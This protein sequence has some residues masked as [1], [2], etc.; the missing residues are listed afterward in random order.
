MPRGVRGGLCLGSVLGVCLLTPPRAATAR[1]LWSSYDGERT[2]SLETALKGSFLL[3]HAPEDPILFPERDSAAALWRLRLGLK[4]D[5]SSWASMSLD[6]E[7]RARSLSEGAGMG[8]AFVGLPSDAPYRVCQLDQPLVEIGDTFSYRHELD[9]AFVSF[10]SPRA[11]ITVGRQAIGWGRG[12]FFGAVD[13]FS[14]FTPLEVDR[15]WRRGIDALRADLRLSDRFSLDLVAAFGKTRED[16]ALLGRFR[17]YAGNADWELILG[18]RAQ[19]AMYAGTVSAAI[20][21]AE[22]HCEL[23]VF[24]VPTGTADGG[25]FGR[26]DLVGVGVLGCS[27]SFNVGN[28]LSL[29]A[30]YHYS[31]FGL[32]DISEAM[33]RLLNDEDFQ[34]RLARGDMRILGRNAVAVQLSYPLSE[35]WTMG[36]MWLL[37]SSDGSGVV[38]PTFTWNFADNVTLVFNASLPHGAPPEGGELRSEYGATPRSAFLQVRIYD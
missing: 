24:K 9:R 21:D 11:E 16:S 36:F 17:G 27:Y 23:A 4:G 2:L 30:E 26:D 6:Y 19:D 3:S 31:G 10:H 1:D 37:S 8:G 20:G 12:V 28:G 14:P 25:L 22:L 18:R 32:S 15:E 5:L 33:D 34:E 38:S 29:F 13:I 35:A 7:H